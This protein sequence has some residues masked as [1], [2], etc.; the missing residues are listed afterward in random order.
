MQIVSDMTQN[1]AAWCELPSHDALVQRGFQGV[2]MTLSDGDGAYPILG[3]KVD[4]DAMNP[5]G[6]KAVAAAERVTLGYLREEADISVPWAAGLADGLPFILR[7]TARFGKLAL[8]NLSAWRQ[9]VE[10]KYWSVRS[11]V[12]GGGRVAIH[13]LTLASEETDPAKGILCFKGIRYWL[14]DQLRTYAV[15]AAKKV[16]EAEDILA[17]F[18]E[19]L[20]EDPAFVQFLSRCERLGLLYRGQDGLTCDKIMQNSSE[21]HQI[22]EI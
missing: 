15:A 17:A 20:G 18:T 9:A 13:I 19:A 10:E 12:D 5:K 21:I 1:F 6:W 3:L 11:V 16:A 7:G 22:K 2:L 8:N 14:R 4:R